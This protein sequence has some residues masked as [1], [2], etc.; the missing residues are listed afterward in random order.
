MES[1]FHQSLLL[2]SMAY[3]G[4]PIVIWKIYISSFGPGSGVYIV[5][6]MVSLID[7]HRKFKDFSRFV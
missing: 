6:V 1:E 4:S 2:S 7:S 3:F 5:Y